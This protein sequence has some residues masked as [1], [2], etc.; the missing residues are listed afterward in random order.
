MFFTS[1]IEIF[2]ISSA[3][4]IELLWDIIVHSYL[5]SFGRLN[6]DARTVMFFFLHKFEIKWH[7]QF[8][9]A[10]VRNHFTFVSAS[11]YM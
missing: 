6:P 10:R 8:F 3:H 9:S 2:F 4:S 11:I 5:I 7:Q 1:S